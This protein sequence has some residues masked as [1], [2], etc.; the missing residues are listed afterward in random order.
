MLSSRRAS[1]SALSSLSSDV[2]RCSGELST[3]ATT[4]TSAPA[5]ACALTSAQSAG[6]PHA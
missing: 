3:G 4:C 2:H 5:A 6:L 1:A